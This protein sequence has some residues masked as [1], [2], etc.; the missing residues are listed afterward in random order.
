MP[1]AGGEF[2]I[3]LGATQDDV[4]HITDLPMRGE[5]LSLTGNGS[6]LAFSFFGEGKVVI[7]LKAASGDN[8]LIEG[9]DSK[10]LNGEFLS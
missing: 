1:K 4:T 10:T 6:D 8:Y 9:A 7:D 2:T 3:N 5:L